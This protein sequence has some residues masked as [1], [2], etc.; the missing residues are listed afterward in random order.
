[1]SA[2]KAPPSAIGNRRRAKPKLSKIDWQLSVSQT[3]QFQAD[4]E[5][6]QAATLDFQ[7]YSHLQ[8]S[9][10]ATWLP[11]H[12]RRCAALTRICRFTDK[13]SVI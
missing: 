4:L 6:S 3:D 10:Q 11:G 7:R 2:R 5:V 13:V 9:F 1:M 8:D 12:S